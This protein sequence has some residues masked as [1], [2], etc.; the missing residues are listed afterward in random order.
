MESVREFPFADEKTEFAIQAN[1]FLDNLKSNSKKLREVVDDL[2][3]KNL[4]SS[5]VF[6]E[7]SRLLADKTR[8]GNIL[9]VQ[10]LKETFSEREKDSLT[11]NLLSFEKRIDACLALVGEESGK[12]IQ[13]QLEKGAKKAA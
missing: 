10:P 1:K 7:V 3:H 6:L 13:R 2:A 8:E 5:G 12:Q 11:K 4:P 9:F